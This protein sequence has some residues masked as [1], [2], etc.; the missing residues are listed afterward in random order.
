MPGDPASQFRLA[1]AVRG[2]TPRFVAL[3]CAGFASSWLY[4]F[5]FDLVQ[6][7]RLAGLQAEVWT[8]AELY[9]AIGAFFA[10]L[11]FW[12]IVLALGR[13]LLRFRRLRFRPSLWKARL[14]SGRCW[15]A[16]RVREKTSAKAKRPFI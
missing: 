5:F 7:A 12:A 10:Q 3:L 4:R 8:F 6:E 11:G 2:A 15:S 9:P 13:R 1:S 14:S 16:T